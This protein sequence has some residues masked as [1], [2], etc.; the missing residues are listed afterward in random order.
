MS[1]SKKEFDA[2]AMMRS[3]RDRLSAEIEG[4]SLDEE[5]KWLASREIAD[6]FLRRLRDRATSQVGSANDSTPRSTSN[7]D[8]V[9]ERAAKLKTTDVGY[10]NR[11]DQTVLRATG[12]PG[13][14]HFQRI[15][16]LRCGRCGHEYGA[17]GSDIH[18]RKC[19]KCQQGRPGLA[20][21]G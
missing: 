8:C 6:P 15:Y 18:L 14:D 13:T 21:P 7:Q 1:E 20:L 17:N 19:P 16:A 10:L 11:N 3:A 5:L 12:L 4:M 2:A 9:R